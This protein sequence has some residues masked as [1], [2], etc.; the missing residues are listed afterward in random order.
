[1]TLAPRPGAQ[2]GLSKAAKQAGASAV[3]S[4]STVIS[5]IPP[6]LNR[7][8]ASDIVVGEQVQGMKV[9]DPR[10][11]RSRQSRNAVRIGFPC[12]ICGRSSAVGGD[13]VTAESSTLPATTPV[14]SH[15][16]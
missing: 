15:K 10:R 6:N 8:G 14:K 4:K 1:M 3:D 2:P 9:G 13:A 11:R 12:G 5:V 7:K 16:E